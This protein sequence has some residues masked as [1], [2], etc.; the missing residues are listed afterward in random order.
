MKPVW[1]LYGQSSVVGPVIVQSRQI[2]DCET[3][4]GG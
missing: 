2:E 1:L 4:N 3:G